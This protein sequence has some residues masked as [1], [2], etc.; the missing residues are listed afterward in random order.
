MKQRL[1]DL[2]IGLCAVAAAA[3]LGL[4]VGSVFPR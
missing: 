1:V 4:L 2:A 3:A